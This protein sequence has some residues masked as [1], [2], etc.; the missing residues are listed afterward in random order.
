[1]RACLCGVCSPECG[2]LCWCP[3][4]SSVV[5]PLYSEQGL[6]KLRAH[7]PTRVPHLCPLSLDLQGI[8][9]TVR[10]QMGHTV[11]GVCVC[12]LIWGFKF[13]QKNFNKSNFKSKLMK[14]H[15]GGAEHLFRSPCSYGMLE[16]YFYILYLLKTRAAPVPG[17][18]GCPRAAMVGLGFHS[19]KYWKVSPA[20]PREI[21]LT[22]LLH[23]LRHHVHL[24]YVF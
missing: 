15:I 13:I 21:G 4:S 18:V 24:T 8:S 10:I 20:Y 23:R 6:I 5:L 17:K 2:A 12:S 9:L 14:N 11:W 7:L 16:I 1:M 19:W 22:T 3:P